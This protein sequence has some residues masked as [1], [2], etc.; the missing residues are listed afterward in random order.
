MEQTVKRVYR[1]FRGQVTVD[2]DTNELTI[3]KGSNASYLEFGRITAIDF[4]DATRLSNGHLSIGLDGEQPSSRL[5]PNAHVVFF[6]R[7]A[8]PEFE[9]LR[10]WLEE[11]AQFNQDAA[12]Q[13][14]VSVARVAPAPVETDLVPETWHAPALISCTACSREVSDKA[15]ACPGCG[16]PVATQLET[17]SLSLDDR[18]AEATAADVALPGACPKCGLLDQVKRIGVVVDIG[19]SR[20]KGTATTVGVGTFGVGVAGTSF[21]ARTSSD[22]ATRF[23]VPKAPSPGR[24]AG[25]CFAT[26]LFAFLI[27]IAM[28]FGNDQPEWVAGLALV[29][30]SVLATPVYGQSARGVEHRRH[31]WKSAGE[32]L[33]E[34]YFCVRDNVAFRDGAT[35][36]SDPERFTGAVFSEFAN[37]ESN[38]FKRL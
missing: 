28:V 38:R 7:S 2:P 22:L 32:T 31:L 25:I 34:G 11:L 35:H 3:G 13:S 33:R 17:G 12:N 16:Y 9:V 30:S 27:L 26:A 24:D 23:K 19:S 10:S 15:A 6:T 14:P 5:S 36:A 21:N 8:Q 37:A 29:V 18:L 1:G 20:T 4:R